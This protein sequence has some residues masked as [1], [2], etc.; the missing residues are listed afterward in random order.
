LAACR[1]SSELAESSAA[2]SAN[3]KGTWSLVC[4]FDSV[5]TGVVP[6]GF[7]PRSGEWSVVEDTTAPSPMHAFAQTGKNT[8]SAANLVLMDD[9]KQADIELSVKLKPVAGETEQ[10]GGLAWRVHDTRNYYMARFNP[11]EK[12]FRVFKVIDGERKQL[13]SA[14][15]Q[16][17]PG[18]HEM[19]ITMHGDTIKGYIDGRGYLTARD[20]SFGAPGKVG[21]WT[22]AD[23]Q[24]RFDDLKIGDVR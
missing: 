14:S 22:R 8:E 13:Q 19:R 5:A 1:S 17:S 24:T 2:E 10:G 3:A 11:L 6:T 7:T 9:V 4:N 21:L 15:V 12:N 20:S 23:A 18:W 16:L